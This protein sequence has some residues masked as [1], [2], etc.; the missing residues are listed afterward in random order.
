[1]KLPL[2]HNAPF[3]QKTASGRRKAVRRRKME[4]MTL[5]ETM[6]S[7]NPKGFRA[8]A[9]GRHAKGRKKV[10][11]RTGNRHEPMFA[12]VTREVLA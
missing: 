8:A 7:L 9:E 11:A 1:M 10:V 6:V 12:R 4:R 2:H 5:W 3:T